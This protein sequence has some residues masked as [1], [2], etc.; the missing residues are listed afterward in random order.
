MIDIDRSSLTI[1]YNGI[2]G[3]AERII[4]FRTLEDLELFWLRATAN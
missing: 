2:D 4:N 1:S 3:F